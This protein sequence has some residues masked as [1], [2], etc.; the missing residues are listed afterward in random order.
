MKVK[1]E[2]LPRQRLALL[3]PKLYITKAWCSLLE[4]V[5]LL[6]RLVFAHLFSQINIRTCNCLCIDLCLPHF[7]ASNTN[8]WCIESITYQELLLITCL[9]FSS[10]YERKKS[11][12]WEKANKKL[13]H[14]SAEINFC[15][16]WVY[17]SKNNQPL[18]G[19]IGNWVICLGRQGVLSVWWGGLMNSEIVGRQAAV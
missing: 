15:I 2:S 17:K 6:F 11:I 1:N 3:S 14:I 4:C 5:I 8:F 9:C 7:S 18:C 10:I 13:H 16:H 12:S 19:S